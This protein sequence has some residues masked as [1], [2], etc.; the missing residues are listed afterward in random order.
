[1]SKL[2][3]AALALVGVAL[4]SGC[5]DVQIARPESPEVSP[6]V[7]VAVGEGM[8]AEFLAGYTESLDATLEG[9]K[10]EL[11]QLQTGPLLER[12]QAEVTIADDADETLHALTYSDVVAGAPELGQYPLWFLASA[13]P[14]DV[15]DTSQL[16]LVTRETAG[17]RWKVAQTVFAPKDQAPAFLGGESGEVALADDAFK[18]QTGP[19]LES[20][21]AF[22]S[23]GTEPEGVT[24]EGEAF[25]DYRTYQD[26]LRE[27]DGGLED[28]KATC[29]PYTEMDLTDMALA[30]D[31]GAVALGEVRCNLTGTVPEGYSINL[32]DS[33]EAIMTS[34]GDGNQIAVETS[35]PV[36]ISQRG[37]GSIAV[38]NDD[39]N[40]L[41]AST[42]ES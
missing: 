12:T 38:V 5:G 31:G 13:T 36:M 32:S 20:V 2:S 11:D 23:E 39:W 7:K 26:G 37:D 29:E 28:V 18:E 41:T 15:D 4:L 19:A 24:L 21:A 35:H 25:Q 8:S 42:S 10:A 3:R 22:L 16:L 27:G 14:T 1:M 17:D 9:D 6:P 34:D 40:L 33:L 30:T